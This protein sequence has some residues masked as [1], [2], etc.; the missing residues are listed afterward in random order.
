LWA[1]CGFGERHNKNNK[2]RT[3]HEERHWRLRD[4]GFM[5]LEHGT[6]IAT[7]VASNH[8]RRCIPKS[9]GAVCE[10]STAT[11]TTW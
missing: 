3:G 5:R 11:T 4:F 8:A 1:L 10:P 9:R 6:G 2:N 7:L